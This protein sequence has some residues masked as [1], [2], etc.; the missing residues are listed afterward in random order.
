MRSGA[1][2]PRLLGA[3]DL[4]RRVLLLGSALLSSSSPLVGV[5]VRLLLQ[6]PRAK[7]LRQHL[8]M[9]QRRRR[10]GWTQLLEAAMRRRHHRLLPDLTL[11]RHIVRTGLGR[12]PRD[13]QVDLVLVTLA[14]HGQD[15]GELAACIERL[16]VALHDTVAES[17]AHARSPAVRLQCYHPIVVVEPN[18]QLVASEQEGWQDP[19]G[20]AV[21]APADHRFLQA[22]PHE[23][24][25]RLGLLVGRER[26]QLGGP[27]IRLVRVEWLA[28]K[29]LPVQVHRAAASRNQPRGSWRSIPASVAGRQCVCATWH[30]QHARRLAG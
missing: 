18:P 2:A 29:R 10:R 20:R 3:A 11:R 16:V 30:V 8:S 15:P 9:L 24:G 26:W 21:G 14:V 27:L 13:D 1:A 17:D 22:D 5:R 6:L 12:L 4:L 7:H 28:A 25:G 23:R 19:G